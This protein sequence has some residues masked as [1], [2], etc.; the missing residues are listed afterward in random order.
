MESPGTESDLAERATV[1][2]LRAG[3][4]A[5]FLSLVERYHRP[6]VRVAR[7]FVGPEAAEDVAQESWLAILQGVGAFE[8]R[9]SLRAWIMT[10]VAN[11]ARTRFG[12]DLRTV[13]LSS[14]AS[15]A[16]DGAPAVEPERF[17]P[18]GDP[19]WPGHWA[20]APAAWPEARLLQGETLEQVS[21]AIEALPEAQRTVIT[22]RDV[23]GWEAAETC[24]LLGI[25]E[26]NQRVL[27]H[28]ARCRVRRALERYLGPG[29]QQA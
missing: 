13:P 2:A 23:E 8:G 16:G 3:D 17:R 27:L 4:E 10:I 24:A 22:L 12:R 6:M 15:D 7:L 29:G 21:R 1:Q 25:S 18:P 26:V 9:S 11:K 28:R 20:A 5:A 14:L 19:E